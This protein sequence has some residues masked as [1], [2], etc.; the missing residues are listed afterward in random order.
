VSLV[1][2]LP[3]GNLH[4]VHR[5]TMLGSDCEACHIGSSRLPVYLDQ[6]AGGIGLEPVSCV[7][8]HGVNPSPGNPSTGLWGAGLRA[9]HT[10][11]GVGPDSDGLRCLDCHPTPGPPLISQRRP[12]N[13]EIF[14]MERRPREGQW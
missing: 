13:P 7:G 8:C 11:A 3:W 1:D 5:S 10:N 14:G 9:H 6:S 2:G 12:L 4:N